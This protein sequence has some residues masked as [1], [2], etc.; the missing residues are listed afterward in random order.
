MRIESENNGR[1]AN[2]AGLK[3]QGA[4]KGGVPAVDAIEVANR[5]GAAG[6]IRLRFLAPIED[7]R[8]HFASGLSRRRREQT[9]RPASHS[10]D[11]EKMERLQSPLRDV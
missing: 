4:N 11:A 9:A 2:G 3:T 6:A 1:S 10:Y 7:V 8:C 5:D